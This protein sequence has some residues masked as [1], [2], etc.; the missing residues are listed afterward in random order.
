M[1][2]N[3]VVTPAKEK[4]SRRFSGIQSRG[5][6][7]IDLAVYVILAAILFV[8]LYPLIYVVSCSF[9]SPMAVMQGKVVLWPVRPTLMSYS[10]VF[11]ENRLS[12][13]FRNT[14]LYTLLGTAINLL[15]TTTGAYAL[16]VED[17]KGR[18]VLSQLILFTMLFSGGLIPLYLVVQRMGF[19]NTIWA[20]VLPNAIVVTNFII[21]KSTFQTTIPAELKEA[22]TIDGCSQ[23]GTL[24]RIVLPLSLP[25]IAVMTIFYSVGH[26]NEYFNALIYLTKKELHPLQVVLR[27][28]LVS[29]EIN[30]TMSNANSLRG[31]DYFALAEGIRYAIIVVSSLPMVAIYPFFQRFFVQGIMVGA[32]KG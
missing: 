19:V 13:G 21:M 12:L 30:N 26:W 1:R 20:V 10:K 9:S 27:D 5:D 14:G 31:E 25:I 15:L 28:I 29:N 23:I 3:K 4:V 16:S 17:L 11:S 22:A 7:W 8:T 24:V 18:K 6:R 2:V 32:V